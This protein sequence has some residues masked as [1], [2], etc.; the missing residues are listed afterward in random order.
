MRA[1]H[2]MVTSLLCFGLLG[3]CTGANA[4]EEPSSQAEDSRIPEALQNQFGALDKA[5]DLQNKVQ[6]QQT[7][8][9]RQFDAQSQ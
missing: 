2:L 4:P 5:K 6:K 1:K 3:A 7:A 9:E 8:Q